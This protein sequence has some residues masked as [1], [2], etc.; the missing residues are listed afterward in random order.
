LDAAFA[1][2]KELGPGLL[3]SLYEKALAYELASRGLRVQCQVEIPVKYR[4]E[5][6]GIGLRADILVEGNFLM[7]IKCVEK[8]IDLHMS[9]VITYLKL[10][11][12][13]RGMLINFNTSLLKNG[14][15][16]ISI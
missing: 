6:M 12:L 9:Q 13:K 10:M 2:H 7:E 1:V 14:I 16:R 3:E 4:G 8:I 11:N 5:D 15:K